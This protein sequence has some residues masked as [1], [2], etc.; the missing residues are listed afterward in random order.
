MMSLTPLC[1][2]QLYWHVTCTGSIGSRSDCRAMCQSIE[3]QGVCKLLVAKTV[4]V[5][6]VWHLTTCYN[7]PEKLCQACLRS[8]ALLAGLQGRTCACRSCAK[9]CFVVDVP[10]KQLC[11][12]LDVTSSH[13]SALE[14]P[15]GLQMVHALAG[16]LPQRRLHHVRP[17][18]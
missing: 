1:C 15:P 12:F 17:G 4:V 2:C 5:C 14:Q 10:A 16:F 7:I 13:R 18:A 11:I 9:H 3:L 6:I 8:D